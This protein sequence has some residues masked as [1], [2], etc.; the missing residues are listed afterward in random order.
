MSKNSY[1][2]KSCCQFDKEM[3]KKKVV[4]KQKKDGF[5]AASPFLFFVPAVVGAVAAYRAT[6]INKMPKK[7]L[8][9]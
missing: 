1:C 2:F 3:A 4:K 7:S 5:A 9:F 8:L 6:Q